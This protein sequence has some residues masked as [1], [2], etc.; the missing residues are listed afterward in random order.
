M[1]D[2]DFSK[3]DLS[4]VNSNSPEWKYLTDREKQESSRLRN[5]L[6]RK[7]AYKKDRV[8][9][10]CSMCGKCSS[11]GRQSYKNRRKYQQKFYCLECAR[12]KWKYI[13]NKEK[14]KSKWFLWMYSPKWV[15]KQI[16][17]L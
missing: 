14:N 8:I 11:W 13:W 3:L 10:K 17:E 1:S 7:E 9:V 16:G 12:G 2:I 5:N 6:Y 15:K 4:K